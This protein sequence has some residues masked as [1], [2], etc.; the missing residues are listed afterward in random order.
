[1]LF[2]SAA[3]AGSTAGT[4]DISEKHYGVAYAVDNNLTIGAIYAKGDFD[5]STTT[6]KTKGVNIGYNLGP[7]ALTVGYAKNTDIGATAGADADVGMVRLIG[8]F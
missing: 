2:R 8:A 5:G 4:K 3:S 1:V 6:Q 7:V